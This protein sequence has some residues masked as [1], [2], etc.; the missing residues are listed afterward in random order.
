MSTE[1]SKIAVRHNP[2]ISVRRILAIA[3]IAF[4]VSLTVQQAAAQSPCLEVRVLDPTS[5]Q[6]P[7]AAVSVGSK[8]VPV[9]DSGVALLC[10]LGPGPHSVVVFAP[11]FEPQEVEA[12]QGTGQIT[13]V[14]QIE[15]VTQELVVVGTRAEAR[16]VTESLVPVDVIAAEEFVQQG[17][18]DLLSQLRNVVPSF[19]V[20]RQPIADAATIIRPANLRNLAPD[21]TLVLVNG[22]RR[23]RG[24]VITWIGG[25]V[26]DGSQG[27]DISV[28]PSIAL[29]QVEVLRDGASAQYGSDAIA[30]VLNFTLKD[31]PSGGSVEVRA[32]THQ[33]GDIPGRGPDGQSITY[34]ANVGMP[35]GEDGFANLSFEYGN[36]DPTDRSVQRADATALIAA[37]NTAVRNP[38]QVWGSPQ[39]RNNA[40]FFANFGK[41]VGESTQVYGHANYAS[42][43]VTGG[44]FFRN[45]NTRSAVFS[46]DGGKTLLVG[47]ALDARDGILDGSA[48]CPVVPVVNH[49]PDQAALSQV[50]SDPNC[51]SFQELFP[52]GFTPNFGGFYIDN[53][54]VGG[55]RGQFAGGLRWD[56]SASVGTS[57][58]DFF[59]NNTVNASLGP[60]T[61]TEFKPG[62]YRQQDLN[63]NF[64]IAYEASELVH[65]AAGA[66]VR[67]EQFTIEEG[68]EESWTFGPYAQQGFSAASNGFP[69]FSPIAVGSWNR[70]N[71]A[72]YADIELSDAENRLIWGGALRFER[73]ADFGNTLNWKTAAR[74]EVADG[75]AV[76]ASASTGF[77]APTPGQQNAFNVS[78]I[79]DITVQELVN[80][81]TIPSNSQVAAL[82]GGHGLRPE[83]S[84]NFTAGAIAEAGI[85][86]L[87]ADFF[88]IAVS[89][90][91][92]LSKNFTL[93]ESEVTDLIAEGVTSARN[94]STFRF[95]VND[96]D[97]VTQGIDI[98]AVLAP[99]ARSELSF[100]YNHTG[101]NV[102]EFD[103]E[104]LNDE[105]I[106][107]LQYSLPMDR[108]N[109]AW[110]QRV[111]RFNL[112]GRLSYYGEWYER[113]DNHTYPGEW[114]VDFEIDY[115]LG[116][117]VS[118]AGGA[119]NALNNFTEISPSQYA[120]G[121]QFSQ[122]SPFGFNGAYWYTRLNYSWGTSF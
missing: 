33:G 101:T 78:T 89:D 73:F 81:G 32:G 110:K 106:R 93:S 40:K 26:A 46:S 90:R 30:G 38:A 107:R 14:L 112:M 55:I 67:N 48:G 104:L 120:V 28:I 79:F 45:P 102:T 17:G 70:R 72:L 74:A 57:E 61:P 22:K 35:L 111:G 119:Q 76:R 121:S 94:L 113:R 53:S 41:L 98:V 11:G 86:T 118:I 51:F 62:L 109:A 122:A 7:T 105:R 117:G 115:K 42:R 36:S 75:F 96:F 13:V 97:T 54:A 1:R 34:A 47:D 49:V 18:P 91:L 85:L 71:S 68:Q 84:M 87:T 77:R 19:N 83:T 80:R 10:D 23:H 43:R 27:A 44:F 66:E 8:E 116:K 52:G 9:D 15:A 25:G 5:A 6:L 65:F 95:F 3:S 21:H 60:D 69:G 39:E 82:R 50:F 59:I 99:T 64:D 108:L 31:A 2:I 58:V 88:R 63:L 103:P 29:K 114:I 24:A 37:G 56:A 12:L 16:T 92:T 4:A 100:L 20:T